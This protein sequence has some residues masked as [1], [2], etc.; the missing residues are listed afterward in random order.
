MLVAT[1]PSMCSAD[2]PL[3]GTM[4]LSLPTLTT[5]FEFV[6]FGVPGDRVLLW[7]RCVEA[8]DSD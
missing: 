7:V 8:G 5:T 4:P 6:H 3:T 2:L 1:M